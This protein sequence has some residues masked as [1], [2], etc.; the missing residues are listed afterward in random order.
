MFEDRL[1][2][3]GLGDSY[4]IW[5]GVPL[6]SDALRVAHQWADA[7]DA[8][9]PPLGDRAGVV[10]AAAPP[11]GS[12]RCS[13]PTAI[14]LAGIPLGPT[15][16]LAIP[17]CEEALWLT[18]RTSPRIAAGGPTS[19]DVIKCQLRAPTRTD[20]PASM[21]DAQFAE[22]Q[23]IFP[24]GICDWSR[25][26]VGEVERGLTWVS[27]GGEELAPEPFQVPDVV[28]RSPIPNGD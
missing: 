24:T 7:V 3:R 2:A 11:E 4:A 1:A 10:G 25:P 8:A 27:V 12:D 16:Q 13:A 23:A 26:G 18:T 15:A 20:Y 28:A 6:P 19:E 9:Y 21:T 22:L 17:G 14:E 5:T